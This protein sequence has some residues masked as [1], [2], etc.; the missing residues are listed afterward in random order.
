[1]GNIKVNLR[2][3]INIAIIVGKRKLEYSINYLKSQYKNKLKNLIRK[4]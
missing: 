3:R 1:M 2:V 4:C